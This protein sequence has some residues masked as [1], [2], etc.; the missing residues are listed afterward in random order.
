[1]PAFAEVGFQCPQFKNPTDYFMKIASDEANIP[2]LTQAQQ[3]R[4]AQVGSKNFSSRAG[5]LSGADAQPETLPGISL[6]SPS[7]S[8]VS[9]EFFFRFLNSMSITCKC[10]LINL[11][12]ELRNSF[13]SALMHSVYGSVSCAAVA[14][15]VGSGHIKC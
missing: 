3:Q 12:C 6:Y 5:A 11:L 1:V 13:D 15:V 10:Q 9:F 14:S 2:A 4:W 8:S 7:I